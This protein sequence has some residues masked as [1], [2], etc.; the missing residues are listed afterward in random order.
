MSYPPSYDDG[1]YDDVGEERAFGQANDLVGC[2][3][4]Q[5]RQLPQESWSPKLAYSQR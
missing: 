5:R 2:P 1:Y 3:S 4:F